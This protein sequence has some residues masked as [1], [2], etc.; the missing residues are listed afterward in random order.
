MGYMKKICLMFAILLF[1]AFSQVCFNSAASAQN[2]QLKVIPRIDDKAA[3]T[4]RNTNEIDRNS[5]EINSQSKNNP[6]IAGNKSGIYPMNF[7][8]FLFGAYAFLLLFNLAFDFEKTEKMRIFLEMAYTFLA[9]FMWDK[10]DA[11]RENPW[12]PRIVI[13]TFAIVYALYFYFFKK[14]LKADGDRL[15]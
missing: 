10:L 12:F 1:T 3:Y 11:A 14:K 13:E 6:S 8:V 15:T 5:A 2:A 7:W 9:I 4:E